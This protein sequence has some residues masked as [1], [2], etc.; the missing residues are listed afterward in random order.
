MYERYLDLSM[1]GASTIQSNDVRSILRWLIA[2]FDNY[3]AQ[4]RSVK[5]WEITLWGPIPQ[6][7]QKGAFRTIHGS[8]SLIFHLLVPEIQAYRQKRPSQELLSLIVSNY[9]E[10]LKDRSLSLSSFK[11]EGQ[12]F[13]LWAVRIASIIRRMSGLRDEAFRLL[14]T[15][16]DLVKPDLDLENAETCFYYNEILIE[17]AHCCAEDGHQDEARDLLQNKIKFPSNLRGS[18]LVYFYRLIL[19]KSKEKALRF[20]RRLQNGR[21]GT[22]F[23]RERHVRLQEGSSQPEASEWGPFL[24]DCIEWDEI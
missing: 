3:E 24:T 14:E 10:R 6:H 17:L 18:I 4:C 8:I 15:I 20:V 2:P 9:L 23:R 12:H 1:A 16:I 21:G 22:R 5:V 7:N 19:R 11:T 13:V